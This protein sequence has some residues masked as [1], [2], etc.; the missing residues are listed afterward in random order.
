MFAALLGI[1]PLT[2]VIAADPSNETPPILTA[3][4]SLVA[5]AALPVVF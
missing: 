3:A 1:E 2:K 4:A 5:V